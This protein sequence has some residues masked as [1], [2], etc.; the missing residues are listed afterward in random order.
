[1]HLLEP[2]V[3]I[4]LVFTVAGLVAVLAAAVVTAEKLVGAWHYSE[5]TT[6]ISKTKGGR[7]VGLGRRLRRSRDCPAIGKRRHW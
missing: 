5:P 7:C 3:L 6:R 2:P 4:V 1:M